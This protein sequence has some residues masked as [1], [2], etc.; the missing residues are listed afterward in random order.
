MLGGTA[1][2]AGHAGRAG[3]R[4]RRRGRT[5]RRA[6]ARRAQAGRRVGGS[7]RGK[8]SRGRV[9]RWA[10]ARCVGA[11]GARRGRACARRL[12]VLAGQLG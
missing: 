12:G 4:A 10:W 5:H 6:G 2:R 3:E 11:R 7:A 1:W 8:R 9:G